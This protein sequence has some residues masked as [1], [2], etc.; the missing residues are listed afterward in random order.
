MVIDWSLFVNI[1]KFVGAGA[2]VTLALTWFTKA[3]RL[4]YV[5]EAV[6]P[7]G[8][9]DYLKGERGFSIVPRITPAPE[10]DLIQQLGRAKFSTIMVRIISKNAATFAIEGAQLCALD[11]ETGL[12]LWY[13]PDYVINGGQCVEV[14]PQNVRKLLSETDRSVTYVFEVFGRPR[15]L[16]LEVIDDRDDHRGRSLHRALKSVRR[17]ACQDSERARFAIHLHEGMALSGRIDSCFDPLRAKWQSEED[18]KSTRLNSSH[19]YI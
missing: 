1:A 2:I 4:K 18:R 17:R 3:R 19:G 6:L 7:K 8:S 14:T 12:V 5:I 9:D 11:E 10:G 13:V 16:Y 15:L